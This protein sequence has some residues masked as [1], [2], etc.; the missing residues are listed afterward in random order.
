[1]WTMDA[2]GC[3][4][5]CGGCKVRD[6]RPGGVN[7]RSELPNL[8]HVANVFEGA[9][10]GAPRAASKASCPNDGAPKSG[11]ATLSNRLR[12]ED[13]NDGEACVCFFQR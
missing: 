10:N 1:M 5:R 9:A 3:R 2:G 7:E 4:P 11:E 13:R 8:F 12:L 6:Q